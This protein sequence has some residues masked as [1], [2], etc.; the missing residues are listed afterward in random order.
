MPDFV[1]ALASAAAFCLAV[2]LSN[3][4]TRLAIDLHIAPADLGENG[5]VQYGLALLLAHLAWRRMTRR[6]AVAAGA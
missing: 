2:I 1:A 4:A 3:A 5:P 6:R